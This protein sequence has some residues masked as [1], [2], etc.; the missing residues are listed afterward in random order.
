MSAPLRP[1]PTR[2]RYWPTA[3]SRSRSAAMPKDDSDAYREARARV[4][5][6]HSDLLHD[7]EPCAHR[8]WDELHNDLLALLDQILEF[9][10][11]TIEGLAVQVLGIITAHDD[12]CEEDSANMPLSTGLPAFIANVC[13][14]EGGASSGGMRVTTSARRAMAGTSCAPC[15]LCGKHR[16]LLSNILAKHGFL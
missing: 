13:R 11:T 5:R 9:Q 10:P 7:G 8:D 4:C 12:L 15:R 3:C 1:T 6:E 2:S 14:F 16:S